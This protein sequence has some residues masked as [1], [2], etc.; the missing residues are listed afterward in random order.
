MTADGDKSLMCV[1]LGLFLVVVFLKEQI[2]T[3]RDK[4][5]RGLLR[6]NFWDGTILGPQAVQQ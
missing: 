2:G 4:R 3:R 5:M 6:R 1:G